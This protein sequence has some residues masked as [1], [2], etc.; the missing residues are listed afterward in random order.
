MG[1]WEPTAREAS[2]VAEP[3]ASAWRAAGW[4]AELARKDGRD[5]VPPLL[6]LSTPEGTLTDHLWGRELPNGLQG[7]NCRGSSQKGCF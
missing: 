2:V 4:W 5:W 6:S 3:M 7:R 1:I